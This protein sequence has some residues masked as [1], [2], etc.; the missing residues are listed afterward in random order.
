MGGIEQLRA[1]M[2]LAGVVLAAVGLIVSISCA[3]TSFRPPSLGLTDDWISAE[4]LR[5]LTENEQVDA[6][7]IRVETRDRIVVLSGV[8][9][10]LDQ[11]RAALQVAARVR[12]VRQVVNHL[13]VVSSGPGP[14]R[15]PS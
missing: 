12:G 14:S 13:R 15:G 1:G 8:Q 5:R 2:K 9:E 4:V 10:G 3:G 11:V 6:D 7:S